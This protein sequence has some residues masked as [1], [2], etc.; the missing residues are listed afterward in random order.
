MI[1]NL[2][3][4]G[5]SN[6]DFLM[7]GRLLGP[8]ALGAYSNAWTMATAPLE[9]IASVVNRITPSLFSSL[10]DENA[11]FRRYLLRITELLALLMF[12]AVC[13]LAL[14]ATDFVQLAFGA[15]W[16][17]MIA[18]LRLLAIYTGLNS[19]STLF[20]PVMISKGHSRF[21]RNISLVAFFILPIGFYIGGKLYGSV[22]IAAVWVTLYPMVLLFA[23]AKIFRIIELSPREYFA[24]IVPALSGTAFMIVVISGLKF[25]LPTHM[26]LP[27][28]LAILVGFGFATYAGSVFLL[29]RATAIRLL[30]VIR[31]KSSRRDAV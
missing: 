24:S 14:V 18:P 9:K 26:A 25:F 28:R 11:E 30:Q 27:V 17:E 2:A 16:K 7:A 21:S 1:G 22:G 31:I 5:Y 29:H 19:L 20:S 4:Y 15:K 6:A 3:W 13:G 8:D 23:Y 12:P 10:R